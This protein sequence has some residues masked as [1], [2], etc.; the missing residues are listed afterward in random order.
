MI[1]RKLIKDLP[2]FIG[3]NVTICGFVNTVR[4]QGGIKFILL[5]DHTGYL[6]NV[7]L[8]SNTEAFELTSNLTN[9]S[10]IKITG[11]LKE[12]RHLDC[13]GRRV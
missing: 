8:K 10:V 2:N 7:V 9:E 11:L 5:R 3:Q 12:E 1:S 13:T 4:N 6:Q